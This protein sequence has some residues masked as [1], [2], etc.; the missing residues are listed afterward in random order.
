MEQTSQ[1]QRES[2]ILIS[3]ATEQAGRYVYC[4]ARAG[5][6]VS[7]GAIGIEGR[8]VY[9]IVHNDLCALVHHCRAQPYESRDPEVAAAWVLAHHEVVDAAWKRWGVVLPLTFNTIIMAK[10]GAAEENLV[11][12]LEAEYESLKGKLDAL[13]GKAEFGVQVFW[14]PVLISKQV[15]KSSPDITRLEEE[16][17]S[18][19]RGLAYMY[20]QKLEAMLKKAIEVKAAEEYKA[21][22][23]MISRCVDVVHVEKT[24]QGPEGRQMLVSL[25]C[26][27]PQAQLPRLE[28]EL[29]RISGMEGFSARLVGPLPPYSFC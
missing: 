11:A 21:L 5:E 2:P 24:K 18:K 8:E 27:V 29:D 14:D 12:W 28:A 4:V 20:R 3:S 17:R 10:Q 15:A 9:T 19:P 1:G 13:T 7:L 23:D 16:M 6:K 25:S 26:L 22:Y